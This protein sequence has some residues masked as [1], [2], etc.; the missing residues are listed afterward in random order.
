MPH[1]YREQSKRQ[2]TYLA[3]NELVQIDEEKNEV[4]ILGKIYNL[5]DLAS[6]LIANRIRLESFD[7]HLY[8]FLSCQI[9]PKVLLGIKIF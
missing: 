1:S 3:E 8:K 7:S 5:I 2:L 9:F 4:T 6:D